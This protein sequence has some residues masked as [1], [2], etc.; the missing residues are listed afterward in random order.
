MKINFSTLLIVAVVT[1]AAL[2][3]GIF[4]IGYSGLNSLGKASEITYQRTIENS[5]WHQ[6][7]EY[8]QKETISYLAYISTKDAKFISE[9]Q[10]QS[11]LALGVQSD[12][13]KVVPQSRKQLFEKV[14]G[15]AEQVAINGTKTAE[16]LGRGDMEAFATNIGAWE[17]NDNQ[18]ISDIDSAIEDSKAEAATALVA[19]ENRKSSASLIMILVSTGAVIITLVVGFILVVNLSRSINAVKKALLGMSKGDLTEVITIK[20]AGEIG[21]IVRAY[22]ETQKYL[23]CLVVKLKTNSD[24][25]G[26]ASE[27]LSTAAR[28]S[29][30]STQQVATSSQQMAKGAQEQSN[31]AQESSQAI[32]HLNTVIGQLAKGSREQSE[33]VQKAVNSINRVA[34]TLTEVANNTN[35][36][37]QGANLAAQSAQEGVRNAKLTLDGMDKIKHSTAEVANKIE[38]LGNRSAEIGKIVAVIDDI[39]A[40]T[41]LLALNAAIEAARAGEQGRG[42]A[43]VSDEV[44]KLAERS[45]I[46]TKEIAELISSV[47]KGVI[48]ANQVMAGGNTAVQDG[49]NLAVKAGQSLE[50]ILLA[51]DQVNAQI[52][53]ISA[54]TREVNTETNALVKVIDKV[55]SITGENVAATQQMSD[56]ASQVNKSVETVAGIAEENSAATE[57]VSASAQEMS[58]QVEEIVASSQTLKEM[59]VSLNQSVAMFKVENDAG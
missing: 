8:D 49:Y 32:N 35:Q 34:H 53:Q 45:A 23:S 31:N 12:L 39:A 28:Q 15:E 41:N 14:S 24:Q 36:A 51:A 33:G 54:R 40:Q 43:V 16:A 10:H 2:F 11:N 59:A 6:W 3:G 25:L 37:A 17:K 58:A 47:Q 42:F 5:L 13:G 57:Q 52:A 7:K 4:I 27:Q 55:G 21:D 1:V 46:A 20:A 48:E 26:L 50:Q 44:R 18:I 29:S 9:A 38:E 19:S 30:E 56:S 22:N